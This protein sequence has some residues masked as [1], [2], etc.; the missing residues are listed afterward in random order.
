M[1]PIRR[2]ID[3]ALRRPSSHRD[4]STSPRQRRNC[5]CISA[6]VVR[7]VTVRFPLFSFLY[8]F[9]RNKKKNK[10]TWASTHLI[11]CWFLLRCAKRKSSVSQFKT[12]SGV[13]HQHGILEH[14]RKRLYKK[15]SA[16][17][18][19]AISATRLSVCGTRSSHQALRKTQTRH[20]LYWKCTST[21]VTKA[22][23]DA[24]TI[25][26]STLKLHVS[27]YRTINRPLK[28]CLLTTR[29]NIINHL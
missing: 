23:H 16:A 9:R 3:Q 10:K 18:G 8:A 7:G 2:L 11:V 13:K 24:N 29:I 14:I 26:I 4:T 25:N 22:P 6:S 28:L 5:T 21:G 12:T 17:I 27:S 15:R 19:R 20:A 1:R